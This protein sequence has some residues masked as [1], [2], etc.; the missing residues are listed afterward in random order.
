MRRSG[1]LGTD[2]GVQHP[3]RSCWCCGSRVSDEERVFLRDSLQ[4][5]DSSIRLVC[6]CALL[7]EPHGHPPRWLK[8]CLKLAAPHQRRRKGKQHHQQGGKRKQHARRKG[9]SSASQ[10]GGG[11]KSN[12]LPTEG[13]AETAP[14][15]GGESSTTPKK[16]N[17]TEAP[18]TRREGES[19]NAQQEQGR[20]PLYTTWLCVTLH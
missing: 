19:G 11:E 18:P 9:R 12:T 14:S 6:C 16:D 10:K 8:S 3:H 7:H 4:V 1:H 17:G 13:R 2:S 15:K 5:G 20:P